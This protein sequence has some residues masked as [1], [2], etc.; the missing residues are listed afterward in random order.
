M[1]KT[2]LDKHQR[3]SKPDEQEK[4]FT[5]MMRFFYVLLLLLIILSIFIQV[6]SGQGTSAQPTSHVNQGGMDTQ[7][8]IPDH[9]TVEASSE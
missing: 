5:A 6:R 1:N 3:Y 4:I 8:L 9:T 7:V 2:K